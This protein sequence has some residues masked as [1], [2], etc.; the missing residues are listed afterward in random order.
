[1]EYCYECGTKLII[2][3]C[4]NCGIFEG[5][6]PY[7]EKCNEFRFP[8]FNAA[9]SMVIYNKD[10]SKTLFIKQ[11]G[12]DWNILVAGYVQK[13]ENLEETLKSELKEETNLNALNIQYNESKY[14]E[15]SNTL[16]CNFVV[17][18]ENENFKL[19]NEVD[20]AQWYNIETAKNSVMKGSLAEYFF[21]KSIRFL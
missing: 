1:M 7:C 11:Y 10:K 17:I 5:N 4:Y 6:V 19:N 12:R 20:F 2:K 13:G 18:V 8:F 9:V 15:K 21:L 3:E 14:F 16:I